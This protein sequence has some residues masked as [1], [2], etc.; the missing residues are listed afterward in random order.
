MVQCTIHVHHVVARKLYTLDCYAPPLSP[1][2]V[3]VVCGCS[4]IIRVSVR[5][6]KIV[7]ISLIVAAVL[8]L[9][10]LVGSY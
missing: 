6:Q 5:R 4:R 7:G 9:L 8:G 2:V 3:K 1:L 10:F